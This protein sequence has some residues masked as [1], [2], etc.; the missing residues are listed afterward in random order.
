[1]FV[2]NKKDQ[3]TMYLR[4]RR[5][6]TRKTLQAEGWIAETNGDDWQSIK[7]LDL[8]VGG[9]AFF[10]EEKMAEDAL[11]QFRFHLPDSS[12]LMHFDGVILHCVDHP[13][14]AGYRIGVRF[15]KVDVADLASIE[16]MIEQHGAQR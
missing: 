8:S 13:Y 7:M 6:H 14:P 10:S 5:A 16:W 12:R 4:N 2:T 15:N 1:M 3:S 9:F 11:R